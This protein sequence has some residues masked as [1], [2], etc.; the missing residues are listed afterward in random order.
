MAQVGVP[1]TA[2]QAMRL[3]I[4][5]AQKG[6]GFVSPNP[7]VGCVILDKQSRIIAVGHHAQIG[8]DHAEIDAIKKVSDRRALEGATIFVTL[9]PCAHEGRTP[10]CAKALAKLPIA[11]VVYGLQDPNPLVAGKGA[12]ILKAAGIEACEVK[13]LE[14]ISA[15]SCL[16]LVDELEDLAEIFLHNM[17]FKEPFVALKVATSLDGMMAMESGESKWITGEEARQFS[18]TLR[19]Q[20]DAVVIGRNTFVADNPLLNV[21][22]PRFESKSNQVVLIDSKGKSLASL[23]DSNLLKTRSAN[24]VLVVVAEGTKVD[25]PAGVQ[26]LEVPV[27]ATGAL[28]IE[29]LLKALWSR[30]VM[31]LFV[32]G[33][34]H[35]FAGFVE[36]KKVHR[37]HQFT[38]PVML[39]GRHGVSWTHHFGGAQMSEKIQLK[40][41]QR[42]TLGEDLYTTGRF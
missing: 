25:N 9:E 20:Y 21:R 8:N 29:D 15:R 4:A 42:R 36:A 24:D 17:R 26:I 11:K 32:E 12:Q 22:L 2:E 3:A 28:S 14:S 19:A 10:S 30:K 23:S 35:T 27:H 40:R 7:P 37:L 13:E 18:H 33:G 34:A 16:E 31:S 39:G 38:A 5:E 41:V 6:F 1:L